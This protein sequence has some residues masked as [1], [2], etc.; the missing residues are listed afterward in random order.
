V[1]VYLHDRGRWWRMGGAEKASR[2]S[3]GTV[4]LGDLALMR[5]VWT[6]VIGDA[7]VEPHPAGARL[8]VPIEEHGA[9]LGSVTL[10][11]DGVPRH[12]ELQRAFGR[13]IWLPWT[14]LTGPHVVEVTARDRAGREATRT[15]TVAFGAPPTPPPAPAQP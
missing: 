11:V 5:D 13:L 10:Q 1:G 12:A 6:P 9:G 8:I 7:T 3:A 15:Q 2:V 14:P 4:H